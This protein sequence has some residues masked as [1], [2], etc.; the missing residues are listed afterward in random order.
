MRQRSVQNLLLAFDAAIA[1]ATPYAAIILRDWMNGEHVYD[2]AFLAYATTSAAVS[3]GSLCAARA[4]RIDW[5]FF[6]FSDAVKWS[7]L[8]TLG[9]AAGLFAGF[10][11]DRLDSVARSVPF[12]HLLMQAGLTI[13]VRAF[14]GRFPG[15][16]PAAQRMRPASVLVLGCNATADV[17]L[18]AVDNLSHGTMEVAG[19]L[20][21]DP[22]MVGCTFRGRKIIGVYAHLQEAIATLKVHG[23]EI[24]RIVVAAA[25]D[26]MTPEARATLN[27]VRTAMGLPVV[28]I[29]ELFST[30]THDQPEDNTLYESQFE[31]LGLYWAFRRA[32]DLVGAAALLV[33]LSPLFGI[34]AAAVWLDLG[35]PVIFWQRR[36]G[37]SGRSFTVYK[38]RTMRHATAPDGSTLPDHARVSALGHA[39]R[40]TR[41]DELPQLLNIMLGH[42]S[43]IGPRPLLPVDQPNEVAQRLSLRP[44][45]TGWA[46][47]T[48]GVLVDPEDKRALDL[49]YVIHANLWIDVK[50]VF[51]TVAM[52]FRGD[53]LN[54]RTIDEARAWLAAREAAIEVDDQDGPDDPGFLD[55]PK[56]RSAAG[57]AFG[58]H[59]TAASH[60]HAE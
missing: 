38:F 57:S 3:F 26:D 36:L 29:Y 22:T 7:F 43:F 32:F 59:R 54:Q 49:W 19:L 31:T 4:F 45:L 24:S 25:A 34:V 21:D 47:V 30:A 41:L 15:S 16:Q 6:S 1:V 17:Y 48:G 18:R 11:A 39:L 14:G 56:G 20:T 5:R 52:L 23:Q 50:I 10:L 27:R 44:G 33:L 60:I 35:S 53:V 12:I 51:K 42:M 55:V 28:N 2:P 37:R 13:G 58:S 8:I 40:S 46:Q 9:V